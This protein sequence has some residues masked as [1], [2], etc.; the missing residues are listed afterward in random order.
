MKYLIAII[1]FCL[2]AIPAFAYDS[3]MEVSEQGTCIVVN[4]TPRFYDYH[5]VVIEAVKGDS[6][7]E[8]E[9]TFGSQVTFCSLTD[10]AIYKI[11]LYGNR[12]D[13]DFVRADETYHC[14]RAGQAS[15]DIP[16][17]KEIRQAVKEELA[18]REAYRIVEDVNWW[19][20]IEFINPT[21]KKRTCILH[22]G[23]ESKMIIVPAYGTIAKPGSEFI[24]N[25]SAAV[26]IEADENIILRA[27][28]YEK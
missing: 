28:W 4:F 11:T 8:E 17:I 21:D 6:F 25:D 24:T 27:G 2:C 5:T 19:S 10:L 18:Y 22:V 9:K 16:N 26:W 15:T 7:T 1:L 12:G 14:F 13:D 20:G 3:G 23:E